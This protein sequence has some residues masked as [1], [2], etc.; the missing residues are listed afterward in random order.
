MTR[1]TAD[2]DAGL[3]QDLRDPEFARG[4]VQ[5]A[6]EEG[7]PLQLA[8]AQVIRAY[9]V[10]EYARRVRLAPPNLLRLVRPRSNPTQDSLNRILKPLGLK[11]SVTPID[12]RPLG[13]AA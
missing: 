13:H 6:L 2:W 10:K 9:G 4:F 7:V 1:R 12:S 8:L 11:L 5:A 3:A